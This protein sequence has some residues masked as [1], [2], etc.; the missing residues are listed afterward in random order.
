MA[1]LRL[2]R[3]NGL[4]I[5]AGVSWCIL[6]LLDLYFSLEHRNSRSMGFET[7]PEWPWLSLIFLNI[8][9]VLL[10]FYY[11][12]RIEQ[13]ERSNFVDLLWRTFVTGLI[14]LIFSFLVL[15]VYEVFE[16]RKF[17]SNP[18]ITNLFYHVNLALILA[19]LIASFTVFQRLILY[20]NNVKLEGLWNL[21]RYALLV[22]ILFNF[23]Y[24]QIPQQLFIT[25]F[26]FLLVLG[27]MLSV[28]LK[29]VA[30]L[31]YRQKWRSILLLV[32]CLLCL[33]YF[34]YYLK[35]V[36]DSN[37]AD[38]IIDLYDNVFIWI[39]FAFIFLYG[40]F[41]L[42]VILFNLP[43]S[44]VFEQKLDEVLN[45]QSLVT[46][47][48]FQSEDQVLEALLNGSIKSLDA[49]AG[50][51][52]DKYSSVEES[53]ILFNSSNLASEEIDLIKS[54]FNPKLKLDELD[55]AAD[56]LANK[57]LMQGI[58]HES[59]KSVLHVPI[60]N[61]KTKGKRM[62]LLKEVKNGFNNEMT[63]IS[64]N[65]ARQARFSIQNIALMQ[66]AIET[67]RYK[68]HIQIA[69]RVH[70]SL[71]PVQL[72][73]LPS[74]DIEVLSEASDE[75]GGDYFDSFL[76]DENRMAFII[77]DVS[78]KGT[79]AAFNMAQMKGVFHS[80]IDS[81]PDPKA[82]VIKTN[83]ALSRCLE[84]TSFI[85]MT[86]VLYEGNTGELSISRAGHCPTIHWKAKTKKSAYLES[87]G[88]GLGVVRNKSYEKFV[89]VNKV[90]FN[91][92]D[93]IILFTD[94]I[95]E[96]KNSKRDE[97]GYEKLLVFVDK[98]AHMTSAK[99]RAALE[100]ELIDFCEG[101][102][103]NDDFTAL[104]IKYI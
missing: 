52:E 7:I 59:F 70:Q 88:M 31:T 90:K 44:S 28:N 25:A 82:F 36:S 98:H 9:I 69:K 34:A 93:L 66:D 65:F 42:L 57:F 45:Y 43:T 68:E 71:L 39:L 37:K 64:R 80:L 86:Y 2:N 50:W 100:A 89:E 29:W 10:Y 94:G 87:K 101:V 35:N 102:K 103:P 21:F 5:L 23:F 15:F 96:A 22:A 104:F 74:I 6:L 41:S 40:S 92:G 76:F 51:I 13:A 32:I 81:E 12:L 26:I 97:Y 49:D 78:G 48:Q 30:Y 17:I 67:E 19:F 95:T 16:G 85:T 63:N 56:D 75:V 4:L 3:K 11:Q 60:D 91:K 53:K 54:R 73:S 27:L 58:S 62:F 24:D 55:V 20:Q 83:N 72:E 47:S 38:L 33:F 61:E 99:M 1:Q 46:S 84:R 18:I 79:T 14:A 8:Y 77:A